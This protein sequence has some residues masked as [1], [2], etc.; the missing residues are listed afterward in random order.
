MNVP[1]KFLV[2]VFYCTIGL[3]VSSVG[4]L[5]A[6]G[7]GAAFFSIGIGLALAICGSGIHMI[8]MK[9]FPAS[10]RSHFIA[11]AVIIGVILGFFYVL[12]KLG[13]FDF[14]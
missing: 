5:F 10:V 12:F 13:I 6:N 2:P 14:T 11:M 3:M 9:Y 8:S 7:A 1:R 4:L